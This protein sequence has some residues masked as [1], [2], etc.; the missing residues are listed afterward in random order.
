MAPF[1]GEGM[2]VPAMEID[3]E[4]YWEGCKRH[5]LMIQ[6]C[7]RCG[8][9]RHS[10]APV[11]HECHSFDHEFVESAGIGEVYTY[12]II[13]MPLHPATK[14]QVPYN[15]V[16]VQLLDCGGAKIMSNLVE[17]R[18]EDIRIGSRVQVVW[19]DVSSDISLPRFRLVSQ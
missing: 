6:R 9:Y 3:T 17:A 13:H 19:D 10:P 14:D 5:K 4:P 2:P 12:T 1:F 7:K 18:N 16:V 11:C 8:T 15:A